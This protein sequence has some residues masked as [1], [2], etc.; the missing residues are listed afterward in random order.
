M[1][2]TRKVP[3]SKLKAWR[4]L[5]SAMN[6]APTW[7]EVNATESLVAK[8]KVMVTHDPLP[9]EFWQLIL[10]GAGERDDVT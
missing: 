4:E 5:E 2:R 6:S 8:L 7:G 3:A 9:E 1:K 10:L